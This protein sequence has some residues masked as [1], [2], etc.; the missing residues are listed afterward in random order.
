M[1]T[2][3]ILTVGGVAHDVPDECLANWDEISFSLKRTDYSGVMRSYSTQFVF[4][5][6]IR[7]LLWEEY[8]S[9]GFKASADI[10]VY[11]LTDTHEWE[12]GFEAP[13]DFTSLEDVDRKLTINAIDNTLASLIKSK[14]GQKYQY[15]VSQFNL[16]SVSV[17]RM[18]FPNSAKF[19]LPNVSQSAGVVDVR[20]DE[21]NSIVV[22]Q[23][24]IQP[25]NAS[26]GYDGTAEQRFFADIVK[27]GSPMATIFIAATVICYLNPAYVL[28]VESET[29][30]LRFC[31][32]TEGSTR[33][34]TIAELFNNDIRRKRIDGLIRS[35]WIGDNI[36][37][38]PRNYASLDALKTAAA[39]RLEGLYPGM[40]GVVGS[41]SYS[42]ANDDYW[43]LNEVYEYQGFGRWVAMGAPAFYSQHRYCTATAYI[44]GLMSTNYLMLLLDHDMAWTDATMTMTWTDPARTSFA[45]GAI[46]P[47]ELLQSVVSSIMPTASAS[48]APD[49][50]GL[51]ERTYFFPAEALRKMSGAKVYTT[52][53]QFADWMG[54]VFGYTY[55]VVG[56]VVQFIH[57]SA[58]F[59][60]EEVK[61]IGLYRDVKYSVNDD[62][63]C[64]SVDAGYPKKE[65]GEINGRLEKNFTNYYSTGFTAT[66]K[67][68]SLISR[69]RADGYGIEFT[70]RK[71]EKVSSTTDDKN[72]EDLF[73]VCVVDR[74]G[75]A[76]YSS[77]NNEIFSPENCVHRNA[78]YI[79]A[80]GNGSPVKLEMTSSDG[81]NG[82]YDVVV[83]QALFTA[84]EVQFTT[85][86][87]TE[88]EDVNAMVSLNDGE[89]FYTGFIK[90]AKC[91]FGRR[92]G[93]EYTLIVKTV[94]KL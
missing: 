35:M 7:D 4:V 13:L 51:L 60:D 73:F 3:Y 52:F 85:D 6:S 64:S 82:L 34:D 39:E 48:I 54:A 21:E 50:E 28:G 67:K 83:E 47:A 8:L 14:K 89:F 9:K 31:Y 20:W 30:H 26:S 76:V 75:S 56:D 2:K 49:A 55:R 41:Y 84:G 94:E 88:P 36:G 92:K 91:R 70:L 40:F 74:N 19:T 79:A 22:S 29:A 63:I 45:Y 25:S 66:D 16:T 77:E 17:T 65:Y 87:M 80:M 43:V 58:V 44:S 33:V 1:L 42:S 23:E 86:D 59:S 10:A 32:G 57:R 93:M 68:L 62:L 37:S 27:G 81:Y 18:E 71:G 15:P 69:Y 90:E 72:D 46:R 38:N 53:Q 61:D 11:T 5:G 24:Y 12:K 78:G